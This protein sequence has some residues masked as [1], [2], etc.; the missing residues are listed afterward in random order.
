MNLKTSLFSLVVLFIGAFASAQDY[1]K[2]IETEF[3]AYLDAIV[4]RE[5][6]KS[7]DYIV[8]DFFTIISKEQMVELMEKT[9]NNP[10]IEFEIKDQEIIKINDAEEIENKF[11]ALLSYSNKMNMKF[12]SKP[13]E[14]AEEIETKNNLIMSSLE[15][16]F[17]A[18]NVKYNKETKFFEIY[19]EKNVYAISDNGATAWKFLVV[20]QR[21][22]P[23]LEQLLPK[24]LV[25]KI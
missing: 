22:K 9:F 3:T 23:I 13:S 7:M 4:N 8:D 14:T 18:E 2:E 20:E 24:V 25:D 21:Q 11:Y 1:K 16:S 19:S 12:N 6:E 5:F 10:E 15:S 17:G